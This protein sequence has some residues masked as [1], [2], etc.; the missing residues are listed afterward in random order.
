[1]AAPEK[2]V[3]NAS[4][5]ICLGKLGHL[6]W[7]DQLATEFVIPSGVAQE[8]ELGPSDDAARGWLQT[9]GALHVRAVGQDRRGY[10][11]M[12]LGRRRERGADVGSP[13]SGLYRNP[14]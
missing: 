11:R 5:L 9:G 7:L 13:P 8:I 3:V 10:C 14:G 2:W 4:P 6:D 1:M 12:G